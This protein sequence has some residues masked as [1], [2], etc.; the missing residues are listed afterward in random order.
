[1]PI[2]YFPRNNRAGEL[3]GQG[4]SAF[5]QN[6]MAA[7]DAK[8]Q[9][10][11]ADEDRQVA[12]VLRD[13]KLRDEGIHLLKPGEMAPSPVD[14]LDFSEFTPERAGDSIFAQTLN[15]A[16]GTS[17]PAAA[18]PQVRTRGAGNIIGTGYYQNLDERNASRSEDAR[19]GSESAF[20]K[21]LATE[22]AKVAADPSAARLR[23]MQGN[24]IAFDM[25]RPQAPILG[26]PEYTRAK[27]EE[28]GATAAA[29]APFRTQRPDPT[30]THETN[31]LFDIANPT[32]GEQ[33]A[34]GQRAMGTEGE[35]LTAGFATRMES[36]DKMLADLEGQKIGPSGW[37]ET[38]GR[39]PVI[40][41]ALIGEGQQRY[42][43]I[44]GDWIR[45]KLRK[46]SGAAIP[47]SEMED[48]GKVYFK[49]P[50]DVD[51]VVA[52]KAIRRQLATALMKKVAGRAYDPSLAEDPKIKEQQRDWDVAA[53]AIIAGGGKVADAEQKLGARP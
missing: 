45:A 52:Q 42:R 48:E 53:S 47:D 43:Q 40:G 13:V 27:A 10:G 7:R 4:L 19:I 25:G 32:V 3:L 26:T 24:K 38:A 18:M 8:R 17:S 12:N 5:G 22:A 34:A 1:M 30:K 41:N 31:R 50:G 23:A 39:L 33:A 14:N 20:Q 2:G 51:A 15:R 9:Q 29:A 37:S 49:R 36:A 16:L 11:I 21:A 44:E 35:R 28:A 6:F 46:E